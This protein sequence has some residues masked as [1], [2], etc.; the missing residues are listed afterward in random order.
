VRQGESGWSGAVECFASSACR[1][2]CTLLAQW[3]AP[4]R[5]PWL[6]L[7]D[8]PP[9]VAQVAWYAMRTW[10]ENRQPHYPHTQQDGRVA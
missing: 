6:I 1:L 9:E 7:T 8:L 4:H 2:P 5:D 10:I 3:A